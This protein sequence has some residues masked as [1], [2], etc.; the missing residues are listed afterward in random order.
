MKRIQST[1]LVLFISRIVSTQ[2][3]KKFDLYATY[4]GKAFIA[5]NYIGSSKQVNINLT[6]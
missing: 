2:A 6:E 5:Y 1:L 3:S 4:L